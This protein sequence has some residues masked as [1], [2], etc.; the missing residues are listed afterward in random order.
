MMVNVNSMM[1]ELNIITMIGL[2]T[3]CVSCLN[4]HSSIAIDHPQ[5]TNTRKY[6]I[7]YTF[8]D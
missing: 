7:I 5:P 4:N 2:V 1:Y 8:L 3:G 6:K